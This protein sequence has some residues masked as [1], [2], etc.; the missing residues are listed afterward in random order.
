MPGEIRVDYNTFLFK[1]HAPDQAGL[2]FHEPIQWMR[3]CK[4]RTY[5]FQ[6]QLYSNENINAPTL[7]VWILIPGTC[8][9]QV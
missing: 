7:P 2:R 4:V 8:R 1:K 3:I 9:F 6:K 5:L